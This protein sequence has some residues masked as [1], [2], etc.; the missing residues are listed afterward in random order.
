MIQIS[1]TSIYAVACSASF[2]ADKQLKLYAPV[3]VP[4]RDVDKRSVAFTRRR[5]REELEGGRSLFETANQLPA[6][7]TSFPIIPNSRVPAKQAS[8]REISASRAQVRHALA[9]HH[10]ATLHAACPPKQLAQQ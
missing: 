8:P 3:G 4:W 7:A 9:C 5:V 1:M 10:N 6:C 2:P